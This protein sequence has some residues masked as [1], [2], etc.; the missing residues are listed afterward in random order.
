[1]HILLPKDE[2][3][4]IASKLRKNYYNK[5][6]YLRKLDQ[7]IERA[8][9]LYQKK[10]TVSIDVLYKKEKKN[11]FEKAI[12]LFILIYVYRNQGEETKARALEEQFKKD[13]AQMKV[14]VERLEQTEEREEK[15]EL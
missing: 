9:P 5:R 3:E 1:M 14:L 4:A 11:P 2:F 12:D 6:G 10:N 8:K 7:F 13:Y 15:K